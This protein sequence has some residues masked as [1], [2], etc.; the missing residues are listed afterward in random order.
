MG[1]ERIGRGLAWLVLGLACVVLA[2]WYLGV[3]TLTTVLPGYIPM[4]PNT[5]LG[6]L[7]LASGVLLPWRRPRQVAGAA[8][9]LLGLATLLELAL[10]RSLGVDTLLPAL[11]LRGQPPRMAFAT[12]LALVLLGGSVVATARARLAVMRAAALTAFGFGYVAV[13]GYAYG[14][15][16]LYS[17]GGYSS[18]AIHTAVSICVLAVALL[19]HE[20]DEGLVGLLRDQGSAGRLMR[21]MLPF[22]ALGPAVLGGARLWVE[23]H[24]WVDTT[25]G[26][27]LLV[28][29]MTALG[30][31]G[32]WLAAVRLR[33]LDAERDAAQTALSRTNRGLE[34]S[35]ADRTS[36]LDLAAERLSTLIRLAPVGI[37]ELDAEGG[38]LTG[39][40]QWTELSG[41]D[42]EASLGWG[43]TSGLH[44]EDVDR[45]TAGW[46]AAVGS[47]TPYETIMRFLTPA[48]KV[49]WVHARGAPTRVDGV[50]TGHL[51][52]I[53][54]ITML[55]AAQERWRLLLEAAPDAMV[56]VD[57]GGAITLVNSQAE[58]LFGYPREELLG[59]P[60]ETL[61][62]E[63][64]R[65][66]HPGLRQAYNSKPESR[67]MGAGIALSGRRK[68]GTEFPAE[69]SL[70]ALETEDGRIVTAAVRDVTERRALELVVAEARDT[71]ERA[72]QS[73]Q[74]FLSNMSHEIRTPM[75]AVIGMTSLL[76]DS[77]LTEE[78]RDIVETVRS[79]GDHL[80]TIIN[81]ILDYSKIDAGKLVLEEL[82][83]VLSDWL[84]E[85]LDLIALAAHGKGLEVASDI[86]QGVPAVVIADPGRLRQI[87]VNLLSNA[88]K[89]TKEGEVVVR[90]S[91]DPGPA[92][93]VVL[94][95]S[96]QDTG[97]GIAPDRIAALFD[98]FTQADTSTTR[99][100]GGTGLGLAISDQL[101]R[102]MG[103]G[104][105]MISS[106]GVGSTVSFTAQVM[107]GQDLLARED[108]GSLRG[109]R[110][111]IVDDNATNRQILL[112]WA[113]RR[114]MV[115][116]AAQS[117]EEALAL[118]EAAPDVRFALVDLMMPVMDGVELG[119]LL[120]GKVPACHLVL[121]SSAGPSS[122]EFP[123][124][125]TFVATLSKPVGQDQLFSLLASLLRGG[126]PG[127][128]R[129]ADGGSA[130]ALEGVDRNRSILIVE[131]TP[132]NQKV[133]VQLLARFGYHAD[134]AASGREALAA[135]ERR[136][137]DLVLMDVQMPDMDGLEATRQI[138]SRWPGRAVQIVAMTANVAP[139]DVR[140]CMEAGMDAFLGKPILVTE[141]AGVLREGAAG[142]PVAVSDGTSPGLDPELLAELRGAVGDDVARE[143]AQM[144][145]R[146]LQGALREFEGACRNADRTQLATVSHRLRSTARTVGATD[147]A[148]LLQAIET[149]A[150][151]EADWPSLTVLA[152]RIPEEGA[153]AEAWLRAQLSL[154]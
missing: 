144:F 90:V 40:E 103:G 143:V 42:A 26:L 55:R 16:S 102:Q 2:G 94:R 99:V 7:V 19:L 22:V 57:E 139:E 84:Q 126:H 17:L 93:D 60:V 21:V 78:Q 109:E 106:P 27:A 132:V 97:I 59:R 124:D 142:S 108:L 63:S 65:G 28:M 118:V 45:V 153:R 50:V 116:L 134:V 5:A 46:A 9:A 127:V 53:T 52:T 33:E 114:G 117:A 83:F 32:T 101:A 138:R 75:N 146:D 121:L 51:G 95:V 115:A 82:P 64:A 61:V 91:V 11:D 111:L 151:A 41:L 129:R 6:L 67:P 20:P 87:L 54:D 77:E 104:V 25:S 96:V 112:S 110:V 81:D 39:N 38:F 149:A 133:A 44:P 1:V 48:G 150:T 113:S 137:Y 130:F 147:L 86:D 34:A 24:G 123:D 89:F 80:L 23:R 29:S 140:R 122:R 66:G 71:A 14:V 68:D 43:W 12:A 141:L 3:A 15:S 10:G 125:A 119:R 107:I 4:K 8:V 47:G 35:V 74:D 100:Y 85:S 72:A 79:S 37:V 131:D 13:L 18:M 36:E 76:L 98:P 135:L 69:I 58:R 120:R 62:P 152:G 30:G 105:S 148:D 56:A 73:R 128:R 88:V 49:N 31:A 145:L 92:Q 136:D 70:S 154:G